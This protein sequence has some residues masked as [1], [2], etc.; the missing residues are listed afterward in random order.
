MQCS[1]IDKVEL[2]EVPKS[3]IGHQKANVKCQKSKATAT[4]PPT[5]Y[6]GKDYFFWIH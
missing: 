5:V 6:G 2:A 4:M 1:S 3:D